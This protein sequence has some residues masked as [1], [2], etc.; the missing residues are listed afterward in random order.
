VN[1]SCAKFGIVSWNFGRG[2]VDFW[3]VP[4]SVLEGVVLL[5]VRSLFVF[6]QD[7]SVVQIDPAAALSTPVAQAPCARS[8]S[9]RSWPCDVPAP[10][11]SSPCSVRSCGSFPSAPSPRPAAPAVAPAVSNT[12]LIGVPAL[13]HRIGDRSQSV[14]AAGLVFGAVM[15]SSA[16]PGLF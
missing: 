7:E 1:L 4:F 14:Q 16:D 10:T 13:Q 3:T 2:F 9:A 12:K 6:F 5:F 8:S 15:I 11:G